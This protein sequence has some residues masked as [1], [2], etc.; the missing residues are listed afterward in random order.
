MKR[1]GKQKFAEAARDESGA[2]TMWM[3]FWAIIFMLLGGV[4]VDSA[5]GYRMKHM[6]QAAADSAAHAAIIDLSAGGDPKA[7]AKSYAK[8]HFDEDKMGVVL[9]DSDIEV[10]Y[11]D[12]DSRTFSLSGPEDNSVRVTLR[13][14]DVNSNPEPTTFL[15]LIGLRNWDISARA[16]S[17]RFI[18]V[19]RECM[20]RGLVARGIVNLQSNNHFE[21]ICVAGMKGL[22]VNNGNDWEDNVLIAIP[23]SDMLV[24]PSADLDVHNPGLS[25]SI[26]Y[27]DFDPTVVDTVE[28]TVR[29]KMASAELHDAKNFNFGSMVPGGSYYLKCQGKGTVTI[30]TGTIDSVSLVTDCGIKFSK[31]ATVTNSFIGTTGENASGAGAAVSAPSDVTLGLDDQCAEGGGTQVYVVGDFKAAASFAMYGSQIVSSGNVTVSA[32]EQGLDGV[33]IVAGG[34][35]DVSSNNAFGSCDGSDFNVPGWDYAVVN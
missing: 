35:I 16:V 23:S 3:I 22:S 25:D 14:A 15:R 32:N 2:A 19:K 18:G 17:L 6:L 5:K 1:T 33:S 30:P 34:D 13:R 8:K 4:A 9:E 21:N 26:A 31:G 11:W 12:Q 10:G 24:T 7:T 29:E 27:A 20:R 28:S